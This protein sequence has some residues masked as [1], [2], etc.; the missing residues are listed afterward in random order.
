MTCTAKNEK[1][2]FSNQMSTFKKEDGV[3]LEDALH[4]DVKLDK[5]IICN[6]ELFEQFE[7][8]ANRKP[9]IAWVDGCFDGMHF[10]HAN[11]LRQAR[12]LCDFLIV[13]VHS[14]A[15]IEY[16]KGP[17]VMKERERY[18]A[19]AACK[20]TD[21]VV[22]NAPYYTD[23]EMIKFYNCDFCV[24]GDDI[25]TTANGVD[26]YQACKDA[27]MY[28]EVP[29]T[30]GISTTELL[31]RIL[32]L[33][34]EHHRRSEANLE[35]FKLEEN[36]HREYKKHVEPFLSPTKKYVSSFLPTTKRI[37]QFSSNKDPKPTDKIVYTDGDFD[38]F[39]IGH[40]TFLEQC[41][42]LGNFLIVGIHDDSNVNSY[43]GSNYPIMNINE[44][45]L[46]V[47]SC[48]YVDEI[49]I[50]APLDITQSLFEQFNIKYVVQNSD[51]T[52]SHYSIVRQGHLIKPFTMVQTTEN[53]V[54]RILDQRNQYEER[55]KK[56]QA[57]AALE[58]QMK[59]KQ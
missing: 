57:K 19:A 59:D 18:L 41:K 15:D 30:Q 43:K 47:L 42:K 53:V 33:S 39:H 36:L 58:K 10:G 8:T 20:W 44:R 23:V 4:S 21:M 38:M 22:P 12:T 51:K 35:D 32:L 37:I 26:C 54:A 45:V 40:I 24:H 50:S 16:N 1:G 27:N 28:Q 6:E 49:I 48:R 56:K 34:K 52:A 2:E 31:G 13:G 9:V 55:N 5:P 17:T 7:K 11:A 29:R 14:D 3:R 46:S 25:T